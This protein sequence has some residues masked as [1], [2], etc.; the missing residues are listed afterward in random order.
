MPASMDDIIK[1]LGKKA[2]FEI[3]ITDL[4]QALS[5]DPSIINS[6]DYKDATQRS[7]TVLKSRYTAPAF[8]AAG[9]RL[10]EAVRVNISSPVQL[11]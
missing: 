1:R 10:Y 3:A 11:V 7:F 8:W 2:T 5:D 9:K 4:L 6:V